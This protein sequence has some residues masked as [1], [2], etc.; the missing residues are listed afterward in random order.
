MK[1]HS[2]QPSAIF[3]LVFCQL[4]SCRE[5]VRD[6]AVHAL[7][8]STPCAEQPFK[9]QIS[10]AIDSKAG[11]VLA[12]WILEEGARALPSSHARTREMANRILNMN[13]DDKP[14]GKHWIHAFLRRNPRVAS[15]ARRR[16][17]APRAEGATTEQ[18][19]AFLELF[20]RTRV[21]LGIRAEDT[22]NMNEAGKAMGVC[23]NSRVLADRRKKKAYFSSPENREWAS[24]IEC[25]SATGK[26]LR[27][28]VIFEGKKPTSY[29]VPF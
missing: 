23:S 2:K 29:L 27:C 25:V 20:E 13:G 7:D 5:G 21:R 19:R 28:V 14:V 9:P 15:I 12:Q 22:W 10:A 4:T 26:K 3:F 6:P 24:T 1:K 16:I 17:E 8:A 11:G 18:V